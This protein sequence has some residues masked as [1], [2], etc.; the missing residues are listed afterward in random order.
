MKYIQECEVNNTKVKVIALEDELEQS[1]DIQI[2]GYPYLYKVSRKVAEQ[3]AILLKFAD[4]QFS[5]GWSPRV[6]NSMQIEGATEAELIEDSVG[7]AE[8]EEL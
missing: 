7:T 6:L 4:T 3:L 2:D 5:W 8:H 1:I